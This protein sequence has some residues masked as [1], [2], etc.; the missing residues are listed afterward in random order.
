MNLSINLHLKSEFQKE[1]IVGIKEIICIKENLLSLLQFSVWK[2][3]EVESGPLDLSRV[4]FVMRCCDA[5]ASRNRVQ[6]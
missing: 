6:K 3:R 2:P 1:H 4:H 5:R